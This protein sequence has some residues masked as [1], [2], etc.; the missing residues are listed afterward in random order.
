MTY[1]GPDLLSTSQS[2]SAWQSQRLEEFRDFLKRDL[3]AIIMLHIGRSASFFVHGLLDGH[4]QIL[5]LPRPC[6]RLTEFLLRTSASGVDGNTAAL[7]AGAVTR[8][9]WSRENDPDPA[10]TTILQQN[11]LA[12]L[13]MLD[14]P[15]TPAQA[16]R[17]HYFCA[18]EVSGVDI[19]NVRYLLVNHHIHQ[20]F[21]NGRPFAE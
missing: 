14:S 13:T 9:W 6:S 17:A 3:G 2:T 12:A 10:R 15:P 11:L 5:S 19:A 8:G 20:T 1:S 16:V 21:K 4:S 7:A 18:A